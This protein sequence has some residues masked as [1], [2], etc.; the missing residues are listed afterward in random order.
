[1]ATL[2]AWDPKLVACA[3]H[4]HLPAVSKAETSMRLRSWVA[5]LV[6]LSLFFASR[7]P[8]IQ[9]PTQKKGTLFDPKP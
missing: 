5:Q 4:R 6:P 2:P 7:F 3:E 1:M 8:G 9:Y